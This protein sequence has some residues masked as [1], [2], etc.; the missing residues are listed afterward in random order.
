MQSATEVSIWA[1]CFGRPYCVKGRFFSPGSFFSL[2][3]HFEADGEKALSSLVLLR[4]SRDLANNEV[5]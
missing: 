3:P 1:S 4:N 2:P 5:W